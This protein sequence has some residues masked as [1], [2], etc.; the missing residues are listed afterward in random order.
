MFRGEVAEAEAAA[1]LVEEVGADVRYPYG[2]YSA[3][4]NLILPLVER[5]ELD[6]AESVLGR[7]GRQAGAPPAL[8]T[9][10]TMLFARIVLR[11]AQARHAEA[12]ADAEE[13]LR[14]HATRGH[15]GLP[16]GA[17]IVRAQL[18]AGD[19]DGATRVARAQLRIA[20]RWGAA[21]FIGIAQRSLGLA[22]GGA[23]GIELLKASAA[24]LEQTPC[25]LELAR[26]LA[27]LGAALR[28]QNSRAEAR[29]PLRRALDLAARCHSSA[30]AAEAQD[31]LR[32]CG[33]RPRR[34]V[35]RGVESL[36]PTERRVA[37]LVADGLSNPE[38]AQTMFVTRATVETHL[39][40]IYR[41]LDISSRSQLPGALGA[42]LMEAP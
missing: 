24:R 35:L 31:E 9:G 21:S 19:H 1:R 30:L 23:E 33:A 7:Y 38:V 39:G 36:T 29:D 34:L 12:A 26:T 40:A 6:E 4:A 3:A 17:A 18:N 20:E 25:R 16:H 41:K 10:Q 5:G 28:R 8:A 27:S 42:N 11:T 15:A 22:V 2:A 14:R 37:G 32:A 13:L